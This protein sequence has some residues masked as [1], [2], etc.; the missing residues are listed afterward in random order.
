M[1]IHKI[2]NIIK[3]ETK[4]Y[5]KKNKK[6]FN[7]KTREEVIFVKQKFVYPCSYNY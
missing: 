4:I 5:I 3:K 6:N 1:E 7:K 2:R